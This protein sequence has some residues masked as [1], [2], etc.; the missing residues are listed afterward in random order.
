MKVLIF[1]TGEPLS[2]DYNNSKPMRA[3]NLKNSLLKMGQ[4]EV[5]T[6]SSNFF[7]QKKIHRVQ[8]CEEFYQ[9]NTILI[10]SPGYKKNIGI[11]RIVDHCILGINLKRKLKK[12]TFQPDVVFIGYPPIFSSY[13][14]TNFFKKKNIPIVIDIKDQWPIIFTNVFGNSFRPILRIALSPLYFLS[15]KTFSNADLICSISK[16]FCEWAKNYA[17]IPEKD[18]YILPLT[19]KENTLSKEQD[20]IITSWLD[21]LG[22][23]QENSI[24]IVFLGSFSRSFD[25]KVVAEVAFELI[26]IRPDINFLFFGDGEQKNFLTE[27]SKKLNNFKVFDW[28]DADKVDMVLKKSDLA[29]AP[30]QSSDDFMMSIPNKVIDYLRLSIPILS[31]L[32]GEVEKLISKEKVGFTYCSAEELIDFLTHIKKNNIK[33]M[34]N[35]SRDLYDKEFDF[36][37][38]YIKFIKV[39]E[40]IVARKNKV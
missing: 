16:E 10:N 21:T 18:S 9:D 26:K 25:F 13:V 14:L 4:N 33:N 12:I 39:L 7:H 34:F 38:N 20:S 40:D 6:I 35:N 19:S 17:N 2:I 15:K 24:N 22:I 36:D 11:G 31:S 1:Q 32:H 27:I 8:N 5:L 29:L 28:I 3:M 23:F 30:Y 37:R